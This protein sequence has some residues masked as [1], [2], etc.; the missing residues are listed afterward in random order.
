MVMLG[1]ALLWL[2][3]FGFNGGSAFAADG[4]SGLALVADGSGVFTGDVVYG[5]KLLAVQAVIAVVVMDVSAIGTYLIA[6]LIK[7]T[8]GWRIDAE[9]ESGG[10]DVAQHRE[11]AYDLS[12]GGDSSRGRMGATINGQGNTSTLGTAPVIPPRTEVKE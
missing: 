12:S 4:V 10:I 11:S 6:L 7:M 8:I 1:A 5:L 2:G 3:W 9:G